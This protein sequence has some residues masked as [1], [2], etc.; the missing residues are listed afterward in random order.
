MATD[1][2]EYNDDLAKIQRL[3]GT[4]SGEARYEII[5]ALD[6]DHDG[7]FALA[8]SIASNQNLTSK[9]GVFIAAIRKGEHRGASEGG[10]MRLSPADAF[11][12]F[13]D[14]YREWLLDVCD[15]DENRA[16]EWALDYAAGSMSARSPTIDGRQ[17]R[18]AAFARDQTVQTLEDDKRAE[19]GRARPVTTGDEA[20]R[21]RGEWSLIG[22]CLHDEE[23]S[24]MHRCLMEQC[25][26]PREPSHDE[27]RDARAALVE[28]I[29][30]RSVKPRPLPG[31]MGE[32]LMQTIA[33]LAT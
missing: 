26:I 3:V 15:V 20:T 5:D 2:R 7:V 16:I 14:E 17:V 4:I 21:M 9:V 31:P 32:A 11:R 13:F 10:P 29:R 6:E 27:A 24:A 22:L 25:A 18:I 8:S 23:I 30:A 1:A 33:S 28:E 19:L 12:G